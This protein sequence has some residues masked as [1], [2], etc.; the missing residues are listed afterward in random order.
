[1]AV[2]VPR[3]ADLV[4]AAI[5]AGKA[6]LCE[7]PLARDLGEARDL[8]EA[9]RVRGVFTAVGL[10]ARSAPA[11]RYVAD[12]IA[13]G[14][15]GEVLATTLTGSGGSWGA[16]VAGAGAHYLLDAANGATMLTI[17]FGHTID[18]VA[19][20]L[21]EPTVLS[22][23]LATRR[24][25]VADTEGGG[26]LPMNAA[27][28]IAVTGT[29]PG[30]AVLAAHYRGGT[31]RSTNLRWEIS[32]TEGDLVI[33]ASTGHLQ[34]AAPAV[35]GARGADKELTVLAVPGSDDRVQALGIDRTAPAYNVAHAYAQLHDDM[36]AGTQ[37]VPD[38]DHAVRRH[39][40]LQAVLNQAG[41]PWGT[42]GA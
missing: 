15:I 33:E 4:R 2:R 1:V 8:A 31:S 9:A 32:G 30:G 37:T 34:M 21:G 38:F 29:L 3:H 23:S 16:T 5:D 24:A 12:L 41:E 7:W 40:T 26:T 6:V 22:A 13:D 20:V 11:I 10:Q 19:A 36:E 17:P 27:D 39:E 42:N 14:Y 25:R 18:A 28:Q 35:R